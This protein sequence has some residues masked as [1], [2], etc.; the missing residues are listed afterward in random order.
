MPLLAAASRSA[1]SFQYRDVAVILH[2]MIRAV[3]PGDSPDGFIV[4]HHESLPPIPPE[5]ARPMHRRVGEPPQGVIPVGNKVRRRDNV[6]AFIKHDAA[7]RALC[8][9]E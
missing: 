3:T 6:V 9:A 5:E 8:F 2:V 4:L 1:I 7:D